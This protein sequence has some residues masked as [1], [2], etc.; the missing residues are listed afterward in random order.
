MRTAW[1]PWIPALAL[2]PVCLGLGVVAGF[3]L[4]GGD[5]TDEPRRDL[6]PPSFAPLVA[7]VR[8]SVVGV[9]AWAKPSA[10][11]GI[12]PTTDA[13]VEDHLRHGTGVIQDAAG[14]VLTAHHVVAGARRIEIVLADEVV[15]A[16][17]VVGDDPS[18]DLAVLRIE[19]A[20]PNLVAADFS[21]GEDVRQGDW[22]F[23]LG[24]PA[25]F[26]NT[27]CAGV[28][29]FVG[30]HLQHDGLGVTNEYL[31]VS[32]PVNPG[33]S[34]SPVFDGRGQV[35]GVITRAAIDAEGLGFAIG[36]RTV[37]NVLFAMERDAGRVRR[38]HMGIGFREAERDRN[39]VAVL[40]TRVREGMPAATAGIRAGDRIVS[41][42][43]QPF[44]SA[45][46]FHD[47]VT[48]TPPGH[49]VRLELI[50]DGTRMGPVLVA[51]GEL[52]SSSL[53]S[54]Q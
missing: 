23:T 44:A 25:S 4:R 31:Q 42:N 19:D 37:R 40:V 26:H 3:F 10:A 16:A 50:R 11:D 46:E 41:L 43:D 39:G 34:G 5:S 22:V 52:R 28:V 9:R 51:L 32:G 1:S 20:P 2:G 29:G 13:R 30:R 27:V 47:R 14:L 53:P 54:P 49:E 24:N 35:I 21:G 18:T 6:S 48:W 7:A 8:D 12:S 38:A 45:N 15:R 17:S 33:N 36:V